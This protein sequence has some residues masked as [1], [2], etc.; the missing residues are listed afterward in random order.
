MFAVDVLGIEVASV[1]VDSPHEHV[2]LRVVDVVER[3]GVDE[4]VGVHFANPFSC[5]E[6]DR[7]IDEVL[8]MML[9]FSFAGDVCPI[10]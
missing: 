7:I 1:E 2:G 6:S 9:E 5:C 3:I 8:G 4:I 10:A